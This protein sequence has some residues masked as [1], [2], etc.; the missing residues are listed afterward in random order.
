MK[1]CYKAD[2]DNLLFR[3]YCLFLDNSIFNILYQKYDAIADLKYAW[4]TTL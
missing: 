4:M 2:D 1:A 3:F